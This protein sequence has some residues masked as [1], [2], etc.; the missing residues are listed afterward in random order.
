MTDSLLPSVL[1]A[2][3]LDT[4]QLNTGLRCNLACRHCHVEASPARREE[5]DWATMDAA[6][7]AARL[8]NAKRLDITGGA[9]E[10]NPN[11]RRLVAAARTQGLDVWVRTNL[12]ILLEDGYLGLPQFFREHAVHLAASLPCYLEENVNR[13]R[14]ARVYEQSVAALR[15]LNAAGYGREARLA[16]DLVFNPA[17]PSLPPS[18]ETLEAAYRRELQ[19]RFGIQF[20]RLI[21]I[22]NMPIGRF[23]QDLEQ[24]GKAAAYRQLLSASF[25][26]DT[27]PGLM[28]R[29]QI[30]VRWDG[31]LFDC[32]FNLALNLPL[33]STAPRH[34]RDFDPEKLRGRLVA[35]GPHCLGCT[36][37]HGSSCGGA[38]LKTQAQPAPCG[39]QT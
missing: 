14:G 28:C 5:M 15:Q 30:S 27:L 33:D 23:Q 34:I 17:G 22:T 1:P 6:L 16:L 2:L 37:G 19:D 35:T 32:D 20:T 38:L 11:F 8:T 29:S 36:A 12:T 31:A 24:H 13:Q 21:A 39:G 26:A 3:S 10:M 7:A 18:Q 4:V 25:N 9:P